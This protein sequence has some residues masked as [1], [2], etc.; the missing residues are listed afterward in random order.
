LE[1][2]VSIAGFLSVSF[3]Y[4]EEV[5]TKKRRFLSAVTGKKERQKMQIFPGVMYL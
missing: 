2:E 1:E 4:F 3:L 5:A